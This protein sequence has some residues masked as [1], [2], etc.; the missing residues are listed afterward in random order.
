MT[1]SR[2]EWSPRPRPGRRPTGPNRAYCGPRRLPAGGHR[3]LSRV[4]GCEL[5]AVVTPHRQA[6]PKQLDNKKRPSLMIHEAGM[7]RT[8][9]LRL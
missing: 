5:P 6:A 8:R 7:P 3:T 4:P 1:R 2:C 9:I